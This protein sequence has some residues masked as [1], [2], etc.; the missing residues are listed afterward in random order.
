VEQWVQVNYNTARLQLGGRDS[1]VGIGTGYGL[2]GPGIESRWGARFFAHVQTGSGDHPASCIVGT[3][4]LPGVKRPGRGTDHPPPSSAEVRKEYSSTC[5]PPLGLRVC[6]EVPLPLSPSVA[7]FS[8][9]YNANSVQFSSIPNFFNVLVKQ[10]RANF[11][12]STNYTK[13]TN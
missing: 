11:G 4:S 12:T 8:G 2:D 7:S 9:L 3:G 6:Y 1:S 13:L 5:T 10:Q